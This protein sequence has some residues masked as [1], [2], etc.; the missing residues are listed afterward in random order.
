MK[1]ILFPILFLISAAGLT[2]GQATSSLIIS[3]GNGSGTNGLLNLSITT[4]TISGTA[5]LADGTLYG[6]TGTPL[7]LGVTQIG[8]TGGAWAL[9]A[10]LSGTSSASTSIS[11]LTSGSTSASGTFSK[12][13]STSGTW[14]A[15]GGTFIYNPAGSGTF[16]LN[17]VTVGGSDSRLIGSGTINLS[18][19]NVTLNA[20][21][22][23]NFTNGA[24]SPATGLTINN[25]NI[26]NSDGVISGIA[27]ATILNI[28][29]SPYITTGTDA[30]ITYETGQGLNIGTSQD[31]SAVVIH[32][33]VYF[34]DSGTGAGFIDYGDSG[35]RIV[36]AQG[37]GILSSDQYGIIMESVLGDNVNTFTNEF[38][39]GNATGISGTV[40][41]PEIHVTGTDASSGTRG[42]D[43]V[44]QWNAI[45][46]T[47]VLV[48][49]G[50]DHAIGLNLVIGSVS[51]GDIVI[52]PSGS[53]TNNLWIQP[54]ASGTWPVETG[55][56]TV[57]VTGST[58]TVA[59]NTISG[60]GTITG[61]TA[62][63]DVTW[64]GNPS[65]TPVGVSIKATII[66]TGSVRIDETANSLTGTN[67]LSVSTGTF[68]V[69]GGR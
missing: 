56:G 61:V 17:G 25:V 54:I 68:Q 41:L 67:I 14:V 7:T 62:N 9:N 47:G 60:T 5:T 46:G 24:L 52:H 28:S 26:I 22:A 51:Q 63:Q 55:A 3:G 15:N 50:R 18:G 33:M 12:L 59:A 6:T 38:K 27:G 48:T 1:R 65:G 69:K 11:L 31:D 32:P 64:I 44:A 8:G 2:F 66:G 43:F 34:G 58:L 19:S 39:F 53:G 57:V 49:E 42:P 13:T 40:S 36:F 37:Q 35:F 45:S 16:T 20:N 29:G 30:T 21:G 10:V 23:L 4:G